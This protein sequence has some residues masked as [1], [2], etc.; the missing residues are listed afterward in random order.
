MTAEITNFQSDAVIY[1]ETGK[2]RYPELKLRI[3]KQLELLK[4]FDEAFK[5]ETEIIDEYESENPGKKSPTALQLIVA[6]LDNNLTRI[7]TDP[8][9]I[10]MIAQTVFCRIDAWQTAA[11][12]HYEKGEHVSGQIITESEFRQLSAMIRDISLRM[13]MILRSFA[14]LSVAVY[15]TDLHL[16]ESETARFPWLLGLK[17]SPYLQSNYEPFDLTDKSYPDIRHMYEYILR[18]MTTD[19]YMIRDSFICYEL[20]TSARHPTRFW[21]PIVSVEDYV[22]SCFNRNSTREIYDLMF[23]LKHHGMR[24]IISMILQK[25]DDFQ[26]VVPSYNYRSFRNGVYKLS[27]PIARKKHKSVFYL[28]TDPACPDGI[29]TE[30][31]IDTDFDP[32]WLT[33][34]DNPL[35]IPTTNFD[36]FLKFQGIGVHEYY[37]REGK[38]VYDAEGKKVTMS[39]VYKTLLFMIG[40]LFRPLFEKNMMGQKEAS[41]NLQKVLIILGQPG[42][43]K[44]TLINLIR[45]CFH[46]SNVATIA[47]NADK[48]FGLENFRNDQI[49]LGICYELAQNFNIPSSVLKSMIAGERVQL[50]AKF[51]KVRD[52][53]WN[54]PTVFAG[55]E[56]P[57]DWGRD[58]SDGMPR[59]MALFY[60]ERVPKVV[61]LSLHERLNDELPAIICKANRVYLELRNEHPPEK[62]QNYLFKHPYFDDAIRTFLSRSNPIETFFS[63]E[64]DA[65]SVTSNFE[66][67]VICLSDLW[68]AFV[69]FATENLKANRK[70]LKRT[71]FEMHLLGDSR[72]MCVGPVEDIVVSILAKRAKVD[73]I[74]AGIKIDPEVVV[75]KHT[76]DMEKYLEI[77]RRQKTD[78]SEED[79]DREEEGEGEG[80]EKEDADEDNFDSISVPPSPESAI[81]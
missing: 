72:L 76:I 9:E 64:N 7:P 22:W 28:Y 45:A 19:Q 39:R 37:R 54:I 80:K 47:A 26:R 50:N 20:H 31:Y 63:R 35:D 40:R 48:N 61:D 49:K 2:L 5:Y 65:L 44:S 42:S 12:Y 24:E 4:G 14:C 73:R 38:I 1:E 11:Q 30:S 21:Q 6:V 16:F 34:Y 55:N 62:L 41:D 10:C 13:K 32:E 3:S 69:K 66:S 29:C 51:E 52:D 36:N 56:V 43:G 23:K 70:Y 75:I 79:E 33:K 8:K 67:D 71:D 17:L 57:K 18:K 77:L 60:F 53:D 74:I 27:E 58:R 15:K 81:I 78:S 68:D 59:R 46:L 25:K